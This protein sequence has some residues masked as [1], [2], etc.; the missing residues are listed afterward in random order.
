MPMV[1]PRNNAEN[2]NNEINEVSSKTDAGCGAYLSARQHAHQIRFR[3]V[4]SFSVNSS[5]PLCVHLSGFRL[6]PRSKA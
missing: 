6:R 4:F 3:I 1:R 2:L 5:R